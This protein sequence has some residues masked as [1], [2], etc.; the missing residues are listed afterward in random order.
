MKVSRFNLFEYGQLLVDNLLPIKHKTLLRAFG[1]EQLLDFNSA[2]SRIDG[3]CIIAVDGADSKQKKADN[4]SLYLTPEFAFIVVK[5]V[6][7][8]NDNSLFEAVNSCRTIIEEIN[9]KMLLDIKTP[10]TALFRKNMNSVEFAG[11]GPI[12]DNFYGQAYYFTIDENYEF[13]LSPELWRQ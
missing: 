2:L 9:K 6:V 13:K 5:P 3:T 11:F 10:G 7:S 4:D 8:V 12:G 1:V